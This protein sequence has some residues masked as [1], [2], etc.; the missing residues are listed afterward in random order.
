MTKRE[1]TAAF[2]VAPLVVIAVLFISATAYGVA[3]L[4]LGEFTD[5][6]VVRQEGNTYVVIAGR[7]FLSQD[8]VR[9]FTPA[10]PV[11]SL[12]RGYE[13]AVCRHDEWNWCG[14]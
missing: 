1:N 3:Y 14:R 11:E 4:W 9:F 12:I 2:V 8:E 6:A 7:R 13:V 5:A 10:G